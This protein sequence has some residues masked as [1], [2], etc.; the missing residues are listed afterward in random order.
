MTNLEYRQTCSIAD[1]HLSEE[2]Q[3]IFDRYQETDQEPIRSDE[4]PLLTAWGLINPYEDA[5]LGC[6]CLL[7]SIS[8]R[9]KELRR[10]QREQSRRAYEER[11]RWLEASNTSKEASLAA[12][13]AAAAAIVTAVTSLLSLIH[14]IFC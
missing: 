14:E 2:E 4:K 6:G 7:V 1:I 12:R 9:G 8:A 11:N 10:Y 3:R 13:W 5:D